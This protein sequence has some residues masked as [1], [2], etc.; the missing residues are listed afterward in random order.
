[1]RHGRQA[2]RRQD[3]RELRDAERAGERPQGAERWLASVRGQL[4]PTLPPRLAFAPG[5]GQPDEPCR[6]PLHR[7]GVTVQSRSPAKA[8][9]QTHKRRATRLLAPASAGAPIAPNACPSATPWSRRC[10]GF[11]R[12]VVVRESGVSGQREEVR[13]SIGGGWNTK[14]KKY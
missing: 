12:G 3:R 5:G 2:P 8:G 1:M 4:L 6:L 11:F 14:K 9:V 7:A 10:A 13:E